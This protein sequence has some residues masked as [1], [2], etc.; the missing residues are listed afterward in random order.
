MNTY[1]S[2]K[3]ASLDIYD[4]ANNLGYRTTDRSDS[5]AFN[6][7]MKIIA[8]LLR[9]C[10]VSD[11]SKE[12]CAHPTFMKVFCTQLSARRAT[13]L[14]IGAELDKTDHQHVRDLVC[15]LA[16]LIW[17][18]EFPLLSYPLLNP[19]PTS[20]AQFRERV[21]ATLSS[22]PLNRVMSE[23]TTHFIANLLDCQHLRNLQQ[24]LTNRLMTNNSIEMLLA[25]QPSLMECIHAELKAIFT[26]LPDTLMLANFD[27]LWFVDREGSPPFEQ[28][29]ASL[30]RQSLAT[31]PQTEPVS[32]PTEIRFLTQLNP[33]QE[34]Y[35]SIAE[36]QYRAFCERIKNLNTTC[37]ERLKG[38]WSSPADDRA[39][40]PTKEQ[41]Y[42]VHLKQ[43]LETHRQLLCADGY[44]DHDDDTAIRTLIFQSSLETPNKLG[45]A[46]LGIRNAASLKPR[47]S[48][49]AVAFQIRTPTAAVPR[50]TYVFTAHHG[51]EVFANANQARTA[52]YQHLNNRQSLPAW[53]ESVALE[54]KAETA[55]FSH[56]VRK[57]MTLE[58]LRENIVE[59]LIAFKLEQS[60]EDINTTFNQF[61][62]LQTEQQ[63]MS[64]STWFDLA[65]RRTSVPTTGDFL[66]ARAHR[67]IE[68]LLPEAIA[69]AFLIQQ[70][71]QIELPLHR[72][73][74]TPDIANVLHPSTE[75]KTLITD[76]QFKAFASDLL[77]TH[78]HQ[79]LLRKVLE[80]VLDPIAASVPIT[81]EIGL[82]LVLKYVSHNKAIP[83]IDSRHHRVIIAVQ[84]ALRK[85]TFFTADYHYLTS[86][87][88]LLGNAPITGTSNEPLSSGLWASANVC[89][90]S[91][92]LDIHANI[93]GG[94]RTPDINALTA[95][96]ELSTLIRDPRFPDSGLHRDATFTTHMSIVVDSPVFQQLERAAVSTSSW[97]EQERKEAT[98]DMTKALAL[99]CITDYLYPPE[100][101]SE[102]Y[103]CGLNLNTLAMG[104]HSI[105]EVRRQVMEHLR[106]TLHCTSEHAMR[107]AFELIAGRYCPQLTVYDVPQDLR[108]GDTRDAV[109]FRHAVALAESARP[110]AAVALGYKRLIELLNKTL[111]QSMTHDEQLAI[112]ALRQEPLLHFAM[113]RAKI[114]FTD[115][116][117]VKPEEAMIALQYSLELEE[118]KA[119]AMS[120]LVQLPPDRKKMALQQLSE[121][122][123]GI[124]VNKKRPFTEAEIHKYFVPRFK[125]RGRTMNMSLVER[126]MTCGQDRAFSDGEL[127]LESKGLGGCTLLK[128]FNEQFDAFQQ[129]YNAALKVQLTHAIN[130]LTPELRRDL[131]N[132]EHFLRVT[133]TVEDQ[134][135]PGFYGVLAFSTDP[136]NNGFYEVFCPS[137]T[138]RKIQAEGNTP[139]QYDADDWALTEANK[140]VIGVPQLDQQAYLTG[141]PG[142]LKGTPALKLSFTW[143]NPAG[144]SEE[145]RMQQLCEKLVDSIF[146]QSLSQQ[147]SAFRGST[148]YESYRDELVNRTEIIFKVLIPFYSLYR[149]IESKNVTAGTVLLGALEVLAF[150]VPF[151]K[152]AYSGFRASITVGKIVVRSTSFGVSKFALN[153]MKTLYASKTFATTLGKELISA[154]NPLALAGLLFRGGLKGVAFIRFKL[155]AAKSLNNVIS[156]TELKTRLHPERAY[157][158]FISAPLIQPKAINSPL[159]DPP[160]VQFKPDFSWGNR[161]L[162]IAQQHFFHVNDVDLSIAQRVDNIYQLA[163]LSYIKMQ[164]NIFA[165]TRA[166]GREFM[167]VYKGTVTGPAVRYSAT[168]NSWELAHSGLAGGME[169]PSTSQFFQRQLSVPMDNIINLNASAHTPDYVIVLRQYLTQVAYDANLGTWRQRSVTSLPGAHAEV[170][171][172]FGDPVWLKSDGKWE[173]GN[174]EQYNAVKPSLPTAQTHLTF[175]LPQLPQLPQNTLAIPSKIHYIWIGTQAPGSHL[176]DRIAKNFKY[177]TEFTSTLHLDVSDEL[178]TQIK[179]MSDIYTPT[180]Q[181][182]KIKDEPFYEVF[183]NSIN[184]DQYTTILEAEHKTWSAACDVIRFPLINYYG[185]LYLDMD[186]A[187]IVSLVAGD[188]KAA[189]HDLL[190]GGIVTEAT[191]DFEGYNTSHFASHPN[192]DML[193]AISAEMHKRFIENRGFYSQPKPVLDLTLTGDAL[194]KNKADCKAYHQTYFRLT[195]PT[196]MNDV[197]ID[198]IPVV[199]KT[200]FELMPKYST[201]QTQGIYDVTHH[202]Q[203]IDCTHH[204]FPFSSKYIIET[205]NEHSWM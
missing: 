98:P 59:G 65:T 82:K 67:V 7:A 61:R 155:Q 103:V 83:E 89:A 3:I 156:L 26:D 160:L 144:V 116:A 96:L 66:N 166:S 53:V 128:A 39:D 112:T 30:I 38:Y 114:P 197:L 174:I 110:G 1:S 119:S 17:S 73:L 72:Q 177:A 169:T 36:P 93:S 12:Q 149:D 87:F 16:N 10:S 50:T 88:L 68:G 56:R 192:S 2:Q 27:S 172:T 113:C 150:V 202:K 62:A 181:L 106:S 77:A 163:E 171:M 187:L 108:Y 201:F 186:D 34:Q 24:V 190:L 54:H 140:Y 35:L 71:P 45:A 137:G 176:F 8:G 42:V 79:T 185:G 91:S 136:Q 145:E 146:S 75:L 135:V 22:F 70:E 14:A 204:Y 194:V 92:T 121:H 120:T 18:V 37:I 183:K 148:P 199:H 81:P 184:A 85:N 107:L 55:F 47:S 139:I 57:T 115:T 80:D 127:G 200:M 164:G 90:A 58:R 102:G 130:D 143:N 52:L 21:I 129:K 69:Q 157:S 51:F 48:S 60:Y 152:A 78:V 4:I 64:L 138:V 182:S 195:G 13:A 111:S 154:A 126:Y 118:Q 41:D 158:S 43:F 125:T 33:P 76:T 101:H 11:L 170:D 28:S 63:T 151:G 165:V 198:K 173:T 20:R 117:E 203:A 31:S 193:T 25:R 179:F 99:A 32:R 159:I 15:K 105:R 153:S 9:D 196:L 49:F 124:D 94:E 175:T 168:N 189:P 97:T 6:L 178:F 123:P 95:Y 29:L 188:I 86:C 5:A 74:P 141:T 132:A 142:S 84:Q 191:L 167:H 205:G 104:G 161:K 40:S 133:F 23:C 19:H 162:N 44:L 46:R 180:L 147:R 134:E 109:D 100:N 122:H 131:L